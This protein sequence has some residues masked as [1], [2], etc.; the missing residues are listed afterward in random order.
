MLLRHPYIQIKRYTQLHFFHTVQKLQ[1]NVYFV[2]EITKF[3][4]NIIAVEAEYKKEQPG[5]VLRE[6]NKC[7]STGPM[8]I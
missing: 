5:P 4:P 2:H 8:K 6:C 3:L 1:S 7:N